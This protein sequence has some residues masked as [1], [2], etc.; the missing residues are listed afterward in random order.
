MAELL[1]DGSIRMKDGR[2]LWGRDQ[3]QIIDFVE[4]SQLLTPAPRPSG[5]FAGFGGG[6]GS[7]GDRGPQGIQ[8]PP[9]IISLIQSEGFNLPL[10][11]TLNF[12]GESVSVVDDP[13]NGRLNITIDDLYAATRIVSS[14]PTQGTDLT[15]QDAIDN[16]PAEGGTIFVKQGTY[17][18]STTILL[19]NKPINIIGAGWGTILSMPVFVGPM[20]EVSDG[21]TAR[22]RYTLTDLNFQGGSV[23]GQEFWCFDDTNGRGDFLGERLRIS[24]F[25]TLVDWMKYNEAYTTQSNFWI[26]YSIVYAVTGGS[27]MVKTPNP[28]GSFFAAVA[29]RSTYTSWLD[30]LGVFADQAWTADADCDLWLYYTQNGPALLAGSNFNGAMFRAVNIFNS[31]VGDLTFYGNGWDAYDYVDGGSILSTDFNVNHNTDSRYFFR[32]GRM[33]LTDV[34]TQ[35]AGVKVRRGAAVQGWFS[36]GDI[37]ANPVF[38]IE[39]PAT[40]ALFEGKFEGHVGNGTLLKLSSVSRCSIRS[41]FLSTGANQRTIEETGL[42]DFNLGVGCIGLNTG[43]GMTIIGANSKFVVGDYNLA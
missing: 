3:F 32:S 2:I 7:K 31:G 22:Q 4:L 35:S 27:T 21:L 37:G 41:I 18:I 10:Q 26:D 40:G 19:P 30:T 6:K 28:A 39:S 13:G 29:I 34:V 36:Y 14:D 15:I 33:A 11:N 1:K 12:L 16:L 24:G 20:F 23:A 43:L 25:E 5:G 38:E 9:G 17:V 8:G 42:S